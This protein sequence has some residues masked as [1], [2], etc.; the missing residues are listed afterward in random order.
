MSVLLNWRNEVLEEMECC[1]YLESILLMCKHDK[2]ACTIMDRS[3]PGM[4]IIDE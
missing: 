1:K 4:K 2:I 3:M